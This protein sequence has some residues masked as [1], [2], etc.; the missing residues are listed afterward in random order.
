MIGDSLSSKS[1]ARP[2]DPLLLQNGV[3]YDAIP[4]LQGSLSVAEPKSF[5]SWRFTAPAGARSVPR[6]PRYRLPLRVMAAAVVSSFRGRPRSVHEDTRTLVRSMPRVP[7]VSG[8]ENL[9]A[10]P[11]YV[12]LPNHYERPS[13][14]W[15]GWGAIVISDAVTRTHAA[16]HPIRWVMTSSWQ[17][18]YIGPK[19]VHPK[20]LH[21]VLRRLSHLYGIILMPAD[22]DEAFGRGAAL[23]CIFKALTSP[24][25]QIV[26]LH[27]EAGGFETMITPPKGMG[28]VL[29]AIDRQRVP[30]IPAGV[31]EVDGRFRI[32]FGAPIEP[33][34]LCRMTDADASRSVMLRIAELVPEATRGEYAEAYRETRIMQAVAT[35]GVRDSDRDSGTDET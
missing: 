26:A 18:F 2:G 21:W 27:P 12:I 9:P 4:D 17:D 20:Y 8:L 34:S 28:R 14:A 32:R 24:G 7:V 6:G 10:G 16:R 5:P 13:G 1:A 30:M 22:D 31:C 33:G 11:P 35:P 29:A 23:R 3:S 25:G 19:R 15:V